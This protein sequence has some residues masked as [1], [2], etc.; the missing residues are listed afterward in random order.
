LE[1]K[2]LQQ[3]DGSFKRIEGWLKL[4]ITFGVG[5]LPLG[6]EQYILVGIC[7]LFRAIQL[8]YLQLVLKVMYYDVEAN[9]E[10]RLYIEKVVNAAGEKRSSRWNSLQSVK[11]KIV[12]IKEIRQ[13]VK[14]EVQKHTYED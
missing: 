9:K 1:R 12:H 5:T 10:M 7:L 8:I 13:V 6:W 2:G 3:I 11:Y 14:E 4:I